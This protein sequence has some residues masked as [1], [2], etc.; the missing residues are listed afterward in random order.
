M[1]IVVA[2][3]LGGLLGLYMDGAYGALVGAMLAW[4]AMRLQKQSLDIGELRRELKA[5][6]DLPT[7]AAA[8]Q[9]A[10]AQ[11]P[12]ERSL[13]PTTA[14]TLAPLPEPSA[15]AVA[16]AGPALASTPRSAR[17]EA[18]EAP[19]WCDTLPA[20]SSLRRVSN[21]LSG[22][23]L[24][25]AL[26]PVMRWLAGMNAIVK[27]GVGVLFVGL[28]FL[29]KF[30][31]DHTNVPIEFR[32][33]GIAA[34]AVAL[35]VLGW[36]LRDRRPAYAQ[37]L[38][39]GGVALL[40]LT[41]FAAFRFYGV[42][43][44]GAVFA[45]MVAVAVLAAA[46]AVLQN[47]RSLAVIG[48]LGG[49]A[50]PLLVST[51]S[52][53]AAALFSYYLLL[54]LGIAVVAWSRRWRSLVLVGFVFTFWVAGTWGAMKYRPE[55]YAMSQ[56]FLIAFFL[57]FVAIL[58]LPARRAAAPHESAG[59]SEAGQRAKRH[60]V[61]IDGGLMFGL[62]AVVF[63]LQHGLMRDTEYGVAL[64]ALVLSAFYVGLAGYMRTRPRLRILFESSLSVGTVFLT[65]VIPFALDARTTAGAWALEG[66]GLVWLG[67]RQQHRLS[68]IFGYLLFLL[69]G[70][71]MLVS[72]QRHGAPASW[73]DATV[74]NAILAGAASLAAAFFVQRHTR[75]STAVAEAV[76]EP[77]LIAWG[78]L[79]LVVAAAWEIDTFVAGP[80]QPAAWLLFSSALAGVGATLCGRLDWPKVSYLAV[81]HM[82]L[83]ALV[84][85]TNPLSSGSPLDHGGWWSWPLA[86]AAHLWVLARC[87]PRWPV[88]LADGTHVL[89]VVVLAA[90]G[91]LEGRA[92]TAGWGEPTSAW[93][94]LG[95]MAAPAALLLWLAG[96]SAASRWPVSS[97]AS[98][99]RCSAAALLALGLLLWSV[100][101]NLVSNGS[102]RPLPHLP[103]ANPL[104]FGIGIALIAAV[105]WLRRKPAETGHPLVEKTVAHLSA[106]AGFLWLN[107]MLLR[108]FHHYGDVPYRVK[109][110]T[111]S[112]PV[113]TGIT[114]LWSVTALV[115]MW[116]AGRR[117]LRTPWM[118]GAA[119]L[120][121]IL[122]KLL[123][124]DFS[125]A[126]TVTRIVSFI[127]VGALM[128]VI[129]YVAPLPAAKNESHA[130]ATA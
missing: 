21:G 123:L 125:G 46:L 72:L 64:S 102:A 30:A 25:D 17:L 116:V 9:E 99:Y 49:F 24:P 6:R 92:L 128:L 31:N 89:G 95:W 76:L 121:A 27:V 94:W 18:E 54:D 93:P 130:A 32:L 107:A 44:V 114:L 50:T 100:L 2:M 84:V 82:P 90:W 19:L 70:G 13:P 75:K 68:R 91:A 85:L 78:A 118:V 79:W 28:A 52:G 29:A 12:A 37:A 108:A 65:L 10:P 83:A 96:P 97:C 105:R 122:V 106:A 109:S 45:A 26:A 77:A 42:L 61:R 59:A 4:L 126:G 69:A 110:W 14:A 71:A 36:R 67:F 117:G 66:A 73:F 7:A 40:Y 120:V 115:L 5:Q 60:E 127:G 33:A 113:H 112:L 101:A 55:Q 8:P 129:G 35:T 88:A 51:G 47:A 38:Q 20:P 22:L 23:G 15:H 48:A 74:F 3:I 58:L 81:A 63:V 98:A 43:A 103:L 56:G 87:T 1:D 111:V 11:S 53:D 57:V 119:L 62:P 41:L 80:L 124:V 86:A 16:S 39:G 34:V 104:D